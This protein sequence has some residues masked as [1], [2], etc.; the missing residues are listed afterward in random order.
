MDKKLCPM[1]S[2]WENIKN[3]T[4]KATVVGFAN[5]PMTKEEVVILGIVDKGVNILSV[6]DFGTKF[7]RIV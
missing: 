6:T 4:I 5:N 3:P 2:V 7:K 1:F